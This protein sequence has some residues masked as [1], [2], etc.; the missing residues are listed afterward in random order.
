MYLLECLK[1][2]GLLDKSRVLLEKS[3][4]VHTKLLYGC[5]IRVFKYV[6]VVRSESF[7]NTNWKV[8]TQKIRCIHFP[9]VG[10]SEEGG[11]VMVIDKVVD[12]F[13]MKRH[14]QEQKKEEGKSTESPRI[15][16]GKLRCHR[17]LWQDKTCG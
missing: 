16:E 12:Q 4:F 17:Y 8:T 7:N 11:T 13:E 5:E 6:Y 3:R 1:N 2:K 9:R 14:A 15:V 10:S